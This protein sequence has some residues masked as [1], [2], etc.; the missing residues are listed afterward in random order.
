MNITKLVWEEPY[1]GYIGDKHNI[2]PREVEEVCFEDENM[3]VFREKDMRNYYVL[4]KTQ[5]GRCLLIVV[6]PLGNG[7]AKVIAARDMGDE[8]KARYGVL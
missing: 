1:I 8:E 2:S 7:K 5:G 3:K 4:G 6:K